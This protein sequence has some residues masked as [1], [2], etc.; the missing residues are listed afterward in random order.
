[1][2][3]EESPLMLACKE[4]FKKYSGDC[5]GF[6]KSVAQDLNIELPQVQADGIIVYLENSGNWEEVRSGAVAVQIAE[7]GVLVIAG[8][9][10]EDFFENRP[11]H[12][13]VAIVVQGPLYKGNY[14]KVWAGGSA[15]GRSRGAL[16]V[17]ETW[18]IN[19]RDLVKYY[20]PMGSTAKYGR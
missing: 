13:H 19:S 20:A 9:K 12:G 15:R 2:A 11:S 4:R 16:T 6:L 1:M 3:E 10:S 18:P 5:S 17:G 8:L 7:N 14:P